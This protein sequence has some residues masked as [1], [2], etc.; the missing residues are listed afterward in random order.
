MTPK[1]LYRTFLLFLGNFVGEGALGPWCFGKAVT[2]DM[3][4]AQM[5]SRCADYGRLHESRD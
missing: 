2:L 1:N 5:Y 3:L 4:F